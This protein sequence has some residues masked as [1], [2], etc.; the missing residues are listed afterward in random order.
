MTIL[1]APPPATDRPAAGAAAP[2][3]G[4]AS[5]FAQLLAGH[6]DG[7]GH[8]ASPSSP[9]P[10]PSRDGEAEPPAG[11]GEIAA[12]VHAAVAAWRA[13]PADVALGAHLR[14]VL[15]EAV[16][17][18]AGPAAEAVAPIVGDAV[19]PPVETEGA[20]RPPTSGDLPLARS[21][22]VETPAPTVATTSPTLATPTPSTDAA[23][24]VTADV[25]RPVAAAPEA[26]AATPTLPEGADAAAR[27]TTATRVPAPT[28]RPDPAAHTAP[29][30]MDAGEV[31]AELAEPVASAPTTDTPAP[32]AARP[33]TAA[34]TL[35][36]VLQ[37][38]EA[39]EHAPPPRRMAIEVEG[40]QLTVAMQGDDV[41]VA[42]R[43][44]AEQL[45]AGWQRD[46]ASVLRGRGLGLA[47]E[48]AA[49][50]GDGRRG[51]AHDG[52]PAPRPPTGSHPAPVRARSADA[53]LR[54]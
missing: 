9:A 3:A 39:L 45:P 12:A 30:T 27:T 52:R 11:C 22:P 35:Q 29:A 16:E 49:S 19:A 28:R 4:G 51:A 40:V 42:V 38:V 1:P 17:D 34:A 24:P 31:V 43:G 54:L 36:R 15:H 26:P 50:G 25:P 14:R 23:V 53:G 6:V 18:H 32:T 41:A 33:A 10:R 46:L 47:G 7:D 20:D 5:A 2:A 13:D 21:V 48:G 8:P 44:G 37:A